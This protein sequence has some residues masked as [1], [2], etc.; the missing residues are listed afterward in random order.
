MDGTVGG[1]TTAEDREDKERDTIDKGGN[2]L[3]NEGDNF[4]FLAGCC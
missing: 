3:V 1:N 4:L 2:K